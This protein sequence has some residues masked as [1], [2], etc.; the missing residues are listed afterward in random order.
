MGANFCTLLHTREV[1]PLLHTFSTTFGNLLPLDYLFDERIEEYL[2]EQL[3]EEKY[4]ALQEICET[5]RFDSDFMLEEDALTKVVYEKDEE[6][7]IIFPPV[8][9]RGDLAPIHERM[10]Y[11]KSAFHKEPTNDHC[12]FVAGL[13]IT[14]GV[15]DPFIAAI[16]G[17][18]HDVG[19]KYTAHTGPHGMSFYGHAQL[20]AYIVI[21]WLRK[22]DTLSD[23]QK[24]AIVIAIYGHDIMKLGNSR[25]RQLYRAYIDCLATLHEDNIKELITNYYTALIQSDCS[26]ERFRSD[27]GVE[28]T[29]VKYYFD[30]EDYHEIVPCELSEEEYKRTMKLGRE[31]MLNL[32]VA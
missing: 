19:K 5:P 21:H 11:Q 31:T 30:G 17:T 9:G 29:V 13:L 22:V 24:I 27:G 3:G 16:L 32:E 7:L 18:W 10:G 2:R 15:T 14:I 28:F 23:A 20:S 4:E 6:G 1:V 12:N 25:E 26:I 8:P